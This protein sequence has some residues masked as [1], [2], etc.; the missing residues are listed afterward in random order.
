MNLRQSVPSPPGSYF[1]LATKN[2]FPTPIFAD[3]CPILVVA[4]DNEIT[5]ELIALGLAA[6]G[7]IVR[8]AEDGEEGWQSLCAEP[9]DL[10]I[11]D[12]E[13]PKLSGLDLVRRIRAQ[14]LRQP[15]ILMS[16][17]LPELTPELEALL[18][19]G[20]ALAKPIPLQNL[21]ST[22]TALLESARSGETP[23]SLEGAGNGS[24]HP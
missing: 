3:R 8:C 24:V 17:N 7:C 19:P 16:G 5:R 9:F 18:T 22:I 21:L 15:I 23:H 1:P 13:M 12:L 14:S 20:A 11:T 6:E 2:A 4:E 10:L